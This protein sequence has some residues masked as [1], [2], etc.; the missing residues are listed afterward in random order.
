[1][2][3]IHRHRQY[4][5]TSNVSREDLRLYRAH[6]VVPNLR[7]GGRAT[8]PICKSTS[9]EANADAAISMDTKKSN[10]RGRGLTLEGRTK[11]NL[12]LEVLGRRLGRYKVG[13]KGELET[14]RHGPTCVV[15]QN[16]IQRGRV[17][18]GTAGLSHVLD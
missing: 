8:Q 10:T 11:V 1:M 6:D 17:R 3:E 16:Q 18:I 13:A 15:G 4:W 14:A 7:V 5:H 12:G 2:I 9:R